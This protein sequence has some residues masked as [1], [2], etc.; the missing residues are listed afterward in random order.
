LEKGEKIMFEVMVTV[1]FRGKK[2]QTNVIANKG[3][4]CEKIMYIAKQQVVQQWGE[5]K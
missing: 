1:Q 4:T 3:M 2:Y 5:N